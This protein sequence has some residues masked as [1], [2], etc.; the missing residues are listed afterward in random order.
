MK[1][2][3]GTS[4][5]SCTLKCFITSKRR[6]L[7]WQLLVQ[8]CYG[9]QNITDFFE[10]M[11]VFVQSWIVMFACS[12]KSSSDLLINWQRYLWKYL[13]GSLVSICSFLCNPLWFVNSCVS[14]ESKGISV[15]SLKRIGSTQSLESVNR[16]WHVLG[17]WI[18]SSNQND[19]TVLRAKTQN[20][21]GWCQLK[22]RVKPYY[23]LHHT[24]KNFSLLQ[25]WEKSRV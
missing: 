7:E 1:G 3:K 25:W 17:G 15:V 4:T 24:H 8:I 6:S 14:S 16:R 20:A 11:T 13:T 2:R 23:L 10:R 9:T 19:F 12:S 18:L 22:I 21:K 5:V